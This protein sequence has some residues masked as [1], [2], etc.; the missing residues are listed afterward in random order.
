MAP[1]GPMASPCGVLTCAAVAAPLSPEY[2][3]VPLPAMVKM[4]PDPAGVWAS[5][6]PARIH[7]NATR[8]MASTAP[9]PQSVNAAQAEIHARYWFMV[10]SLRSVQGSAVRHRR[11]A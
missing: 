3:A 11:D 6:T 7:P 4:V 9:V 1:S 2:P 5:A 10:D 8:T